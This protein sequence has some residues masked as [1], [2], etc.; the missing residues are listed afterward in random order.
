MKLGLAQLPVCGIVGATTICRC[1]LS[2]I[3]PSFVR[4]TGDRKQCLRRSQ[5]LNVAAYEIRMEMRFDNIFNFEIR[6]SGSFQ[7]KFNIS[8]RVD[9]CG[10]AGGTDQVGRVGQTSEIEL[11]KVHKRIAGGKASS[12]A[13]RK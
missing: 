5:I 8:L 4:K 3:D 9:D 1:D 6:P 12:E 7:V 10:A 11:L 13:L 2:S